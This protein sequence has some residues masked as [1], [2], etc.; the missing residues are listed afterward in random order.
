MAI[1]PWLQKIVDKFNPDGL[2]C[3][4][5][6]SDALRISENTVLNRIRCGEIGGIKIGAIYRIPGSEVIRFINNQVIS[7]KSKEPVAASKCLMMS[8]PRI[9]TDARA[10]GI[11]LMDQGLSDTAIARELNKMGFSNKKGQ[12]YDVYSSLYNNYSMNYCRPDVMVASTRKTQVPRYRKI[13]PPA[14]SGAP[15][16]KPPVTK[17]WRRSSDR[18][19]ECKMALDE[20]VSNN[21]DGEAEYL[22]RLKCSNEAFCKYNKPIDPPKMIK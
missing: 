7:K 9:K 5:E 19:P 11:N 6:I 4:R 21:P 14:A 3:V 22:Y 13:K 8:P 17:Y 12:P 10:Q 18:C 20:Q 15:L 16:P 1:N 2:Y